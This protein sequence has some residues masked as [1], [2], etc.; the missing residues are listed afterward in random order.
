MINKPKNDVILLDGRILIFVFVLINCCI[1]NV[2][3][4]NAIVEYLSKNNFLV[5]KAEIVFLLDRSGS[6]G[7]AN[8]ETEKGFVESFLTH[9]VVDANASRVAV[10]S[11]SDAAGE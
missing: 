7:N 9:I 5:G 4:E 10:I 3:E 8:F 11:Y 2:K 1:A 6:V